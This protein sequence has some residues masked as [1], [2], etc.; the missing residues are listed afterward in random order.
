MAT[1][2]GKDQGSLDSLDGAPATVRNAVTALRALY[3]WAIPR[4][5]AQVNPTRDLRLP[6]GEKARDR[7]ASPA[8]AATLIAALQPRDQALFGLAVY[9]GLRLGRF[10]RW[11]GRR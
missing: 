7:V 2:N 8:E 11:S 4:N 3:G 10:W 5:L 9:A 6:S 1:D